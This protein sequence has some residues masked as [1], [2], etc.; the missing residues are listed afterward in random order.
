M[1]KALHAAFPGARTV[2]DAVSDALGYDMAALCFDGSDADLK[3]TENTQPSV[4]TMSVAAFRVLEAEAGFA[5]VVAAGHSLGEYSSLVAAGVLDLAEAARVLRNRGRYMQEAVPEGEG[6]MAAVLGL[7][8]ETLMS[9]CRAAEGVGAVAPANFNGG[10]QIVISGSAKAVASASEGAKA[11]GAK[12][13]IPLQVSAPFHSSLMLPAADRLRP[14]LD[15]LAVSPF[16][17]PI[18]ANVTADRYPSEAAVADTLWRQIPSPV[19]WEESVKAMV[20]MGVTAFVEVGP[21]KVLAGLVRRIAP[22]LPVVSFGSPE[23]LP[24]VVAILA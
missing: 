16:R 22:D 11:A 5:P 1:G 19:R 23:D 7:S 4:F 2:F 18:V 13:V 3:R 14:E 15:A 8:A 24:S 6:A 17:F 20:A 9:V 12:R 21:G 10:D